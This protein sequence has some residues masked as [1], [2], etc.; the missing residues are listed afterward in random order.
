MKIY[1]V[2]TCIYGISLLIEAQK[3]Q[4]DEPDDADLNAAPSEIR[5]WHLKSA[6]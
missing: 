4:S 2:H 3:T 5:P 6:R 1:T